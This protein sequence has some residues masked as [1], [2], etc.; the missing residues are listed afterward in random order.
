MTCDGCSLC[1]YLFFLQG[2]HKH[3]GGPCEVILVPDIRY[4]AAE[5]NT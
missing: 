1:H 2:L 4:G 5:R 3:L